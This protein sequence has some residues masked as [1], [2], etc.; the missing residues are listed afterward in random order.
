MRSSELHKDV[1]TSGI[2]DFIGFR[3]QFAFIHAS[4]HR[5]RTDG[6]TRFD[7]FGA[8]LPQ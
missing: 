2:C 1:R 3:D 8:D 5:V 4:N 6:S 7:R